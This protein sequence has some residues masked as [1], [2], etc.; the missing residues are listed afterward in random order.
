MKKTSYIIATMV[1]ASILFAGCSAG[2]NG[3]I[4]TKTSGTQA[5]TQMSMAPVKPPELTSQQ[6]D[7]LQAGIKAHTPTTLT[8]NVGGGNFYYVPNVIKVKQG[9]TVKII[10]TN[11]GGFH[12]F[13]LDE[14]GI[15]FNPINTGETKTVQFVADKKGRFEYYCSVANHR[16]KGQRGQFVVE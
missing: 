9:D 6:L 1:V 12:N 10:F 15:K 8:F 4:N 13:T 3:A 2:D 16:Q 5:G 11:N 14:F 7:E